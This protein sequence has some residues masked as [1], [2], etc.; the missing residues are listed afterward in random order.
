MADVAP[1]NQQL[2]DPDTRPLDPETQDGSDRQTALSNSPDSPRF[3]GG[4]IV[5]GVFAMMFSMTLLAIVLPSLVLRSDEQQ[6]D[7]YGDMPTFELVDHTGAAIG[8]SQLRD[9]VVV[10]NFIFT[11]CPT[12]CPMMSARMYQVQE[13]SKDLAGDLKLV[14]FSVDP[15]YDTPEILSEY[16][17]AH[18][19]DPERWRF[20]TGD[21]ETI[22][23]MANDGFALA[24]ERR[25]TDVTGVPDISHAE[26][27][28][29]L[30]R[31]GRIR[32]YYNS[33]DAKRVSQMLRDARRLAIRTR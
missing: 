9:N 10:A 2:P 27:F 7:I 20:V 3:S 5:L 15:E 12:V 21:I 31:S 28:V 14:S 33:N 1:V 26:H 19:T 30:D 25:G 32:G 23:T 11:R 29:L 4:K 13:Q 18:K 22:R 8:D 6:L 16:A 17:R 24:M